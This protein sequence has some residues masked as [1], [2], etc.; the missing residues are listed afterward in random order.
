MTNGHGHT[1]NLVPYAGP[2]DFRQLSSAKVQ[3]QIL[4][5]CMQDS[6]ILLKALDVDLHLVNTDVFEIGLEIE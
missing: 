2:N 4:A 5:T 6:P 3:L 1:Y